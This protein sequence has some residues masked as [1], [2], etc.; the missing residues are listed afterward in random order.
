MRNCIALG[1]PACSALL[2]LAA[3]A[4]V[5][6]KGGNP[7]DYFPLAAGHRWFYTLN[8]EGEQSEVS[9]RVTE[10]MGDE[11]ALRQEILA[12]Y[13]EIYFPFVLDQDIGFIRSDT[14][15]IRDPGSPFLLLKLPLE[16]GTSWS[17]GDDSAWV[18]DRVTV[19]VPA[20]VFE[21]CYRIGYRVGGE[22]V[23]VWYA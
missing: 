18:G 14:G 13:L 2:G 11:F 17:N 20:G 9:V 19:S 3:L 6:C 7:R 15:V 8:E 21:D 23:T 12:G 22:E 4:L 10:Q 5:Q 1:R 16:V